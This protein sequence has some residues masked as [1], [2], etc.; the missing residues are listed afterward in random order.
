M[1]FVKLEMR[2][3]FH[4]RVCVR[5]CLLRIRLGDRRF[6][7][8]SRGSEGKGNALFLLSSLFVHTHRTRP[9]SLW[10]PPLATSR[11]CGGWHGVRDGG[12]GHRKLARTYPTRPCQLA[13]ST[14]WPVLAG[15]CAKIWRRRG[16]T[17]CRALSTN[18]GSIYF[19][20]L[21]RRVLA[22][23]FLV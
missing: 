21:R 18:P 3:P 6:C 23:T 14:F 22:S 5:L 7:D 20:P 15:R 1:V 19:S 12:G 4:R 16:L 11:R 17:Q 13:G 2:R 8:C 10:T 9:A